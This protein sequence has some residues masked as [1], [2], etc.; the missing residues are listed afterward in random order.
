MKTKQKILKVVLLCVFTICAVS[1]K[2]NVDEP[3]TPSWNYSTFTDSRD[4]KIYKSIVIGTQEWMADNLAFKTETGSWIYG[5]SVELGDKYGRLY[6]W[7]AAIIAV[8][9]GWHLPTDS[10][11]KLLELTLGM[12]QT[13]ADNIEGRGTNQGEQLKAVTGWAENG[14]GTD[15]VGFASLPGGFRTNSGD[16]YVENWAG[17]WWTSTENNSSDAWFRYI[18]TANPKV[19]R[20]IGYKEDAYSV[21]CIKD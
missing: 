12:S 3:I 18:A 5:G 9:A 1:C 15:M 20:K 10:E 14:G 19:Y 2:K 6:T 13:D 4:G 17:Y 7:D 16:C 21:R 8:P 11:W